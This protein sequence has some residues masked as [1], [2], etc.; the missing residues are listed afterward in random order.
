LKYQQAIH[1]RVQWK[2]RE[3][4]V[5]FLSSD[6]IEDQKPIRPLANGEDWQVINRYYM[7]GVCEWTLRAATKDLLD[8]AQTLIEKAYET[9]RGAK[10]I[11][12]LM[13]PDSSKFGRIIRMGG[14]TVNKLQHNTNTT[15]VVP[16]IIEEDQTIQITGMSWHTA[17]LGADG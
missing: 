12:F 11:G 7:V 14:E 4:D 10:Y 16:N 5:R 8:Q 17:F 15:I 13:L 6:L 3:M 1:E 2:L 9:A